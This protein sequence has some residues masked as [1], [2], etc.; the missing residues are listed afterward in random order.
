LEGSGVGV[1]AEVVSMPEGAWPAALSRVSAA[2]IEVHDEGSE[3]GVAWYS[4][5]RGA[6]RVGLAYCPGDREATVYAPEIRFWRRPL[7]MWWLYR[8]VRRAL[9]DV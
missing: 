8:D 6:C 7:G 5:R 9:R 1:V 2:G 4:C 3:P